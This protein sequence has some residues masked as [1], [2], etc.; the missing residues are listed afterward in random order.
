MFCTWCRTVYPAQITIEVNRSV[1][2]ITEAYPEDSGKYTV[3]L[4]NAAGETQKSVQVNVESF[5]SSTA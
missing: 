2:E 3:V 5:Y 1:L 4:Q